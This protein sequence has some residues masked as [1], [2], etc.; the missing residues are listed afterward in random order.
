[1]S[2]KPER[3]YV[4]RGF[5]FLNESFAQPTGIIDDKNSFKELAVKTQAEAVVAMLSDDEIGTMMVPAILDR[6]D[7]LSRVGEGDLAVREPQNVLQVIDL[8]IAFASD[9]KQEVRQIKTPLREVLKRWAE[10][11]RVKNRRG[12]RA[13]AI[14]TPKFEYESGAAC[15]RVQVILSNAIL[16][17][18]HATNLTP[19]SYLSITDD[20]ALLRKEL[21]KQLGS[22]FD[23]LRF[24]HSIIGA[25]E[26][27]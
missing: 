1:M 21:V 10:K 24:H 18:S 8:T 25:G 17:S 15:A 26:V 19:P 9:D 5:D 16:Y 22:M 12:Y 7:H 13:S 14:R 6:T 27:L 20:L 2:K 23:G 3:Y 11:S 4:V